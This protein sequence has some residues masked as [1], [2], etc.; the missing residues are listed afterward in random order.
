MEF[1]V[2]YENN[3]GWTIEKSTRNEEEAKFYKWHLEA[4]GKKAKIFVWISTYID[5]YSIDYEDWKK[6]K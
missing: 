2:C 6:R 3:G 4:H 5:S 1:R